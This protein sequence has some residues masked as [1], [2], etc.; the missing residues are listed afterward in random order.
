MDAK[1]LAP[2]GHMEDLE[3]PTPLDANLAVL[4]DSVPVRWRCFKDRNAVTRGCL[5]QELER[6]VA[7]RQTRLAELRP[8]L[9]VPSRRKT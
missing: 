6:K 2:Y 4:Q 3:K 8:Q 9:A 1:V 7:L 5:K